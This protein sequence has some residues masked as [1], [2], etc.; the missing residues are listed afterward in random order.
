MNRMMHI[1]A[2][3]LC[4]AFAATT[5]ASTI[6]DFYFRYDFSSGKNVFIGSGSL[7]SDPLSNNNTLTPVYGP[8]GDFNAVHLTG[9]KWGA[10][11]SSI[12]NADWSVAMCVRMGSVEN[13]VVASFG[14][15]SDKK[16]KALGLLSSSDTTKIKVRVVK[17]TDSNNKRSDEKEL[18]I[19]VPDTTGFH[20]VV[21]VHHSNSSDKGT[22][23]FYWDGVFKCSYTTTTAYPL[24]NVIQF[25]AIPS[26][27]TSNC[28]NSDNNP[29]VAFNDVRFF[30]RALDG[31]DA[32]DFA[33]LHPA[34]TL[35]QPAYIEAAGVNYIDTGYYTKPNTRYT[36]DFNYLDLT[37]QDRIFGTGGD[38]GCNVYI[39]SDT[40]YGYAMRD[41]GAGW[42]TWGTRVDYRRNVATLDATN[43]LATLRL[44]QDARVVE[45]TL[46][47]TRNNTASKTTWLFNQNGSTSEYSESRIYSFA[48]DEISVVNEQQVATPTMFLVPYY[49]ETSGACFTNIVSGGL[50][51]EGNGTSATT[52]LSYFGG[53]G[54]LSDYKYEGGILSARIY[55]KTADSSKGL[56]QVG[57]EAAAASPEIWLAHDESV[58]LTAVPQNGAKFIGWAGDVGLIQ[59]DAT[60]TNLT[61]T[62]KSSS[63]AQ[64]EA[65]FGEGEWDERYDSTLGERFAKRA[66]DFDVGDYVQDGL[67][68]NF[69]GIRNAGATADHDSSASTWA[70]LGTLGSAANATKTAL[71]S[72]IPSG[73]VAG[74]W[75]DDGYQ[76]GGLEYFAL[77]GTVDLGSKFT[78]QIVQE[79]DDADQL[80]SWPIFF[81]ATSAD[82]D[83]FGIYCNRANSGTETNPLFKLKTKT[84][85]DSG[86]ALVS[87]YLN[88]IYDG[89]TPQVS[90]NSAVLPQWQKSNASG[91][92]PAWSYAIGTAGNTDS[93]RKPRTLV[94]KVSSVRAYNRILTDAEL[95]L[96][97]LVDDA[98]F[99]GKIDV[100][101]VVASNGSGLS[102]AEEGE[103]MVNGNHIFTAPASVARSDGTVWEPAGYKLE[104]WNDNGSWTLLGEYDGASYAYTNCAALAKVRLTWNWKMTSG[105]KKIDV[106]DYVQGGLLLNFDGIRNVGATAN[107]D[108]SATTW[109]NLGSLGSAV[110]ATNAVLSSTYWHANSSAGSWTDKGYFFKCRDFF[111][112]K[113]EVELSDAATSQ[114]VMDFDSAAATT[115]YTSS[116]IRWPCFYGTIDTA[117]HFIAYVNIEGDK[118]DNVY[119][120][121]HGDS[122]YRNQA[123]KWDGRYI[124]RVFDS[125]TSQSD[126][127]YVSI[128]SSWSTGT[129]AVPFGSEI[130]SHLLAI[131]TGSS[132]S[133]S[134][135][136]SHIGYG[137]VHAVR[138]YDRVLSESEMQH[139]KEIDEARFFGRIAAISET[140]VVLAR[141]ESAGGAVTLDDD[142]AYILR[143]SGSK[144]FSAPETVEV[145]GRTYTCSGYCLET[146]NAT[147]GLWETTSSSSD[148]EVTLS[149]TTD[150]ANRRLTWL[151]TLTKGLRTADD[152]TTADYVQCGLA[153][154]FDG[155]SNYG[156]SQSH[157]TSAARWVN[158]ADGG[159]DAD[160]TTLGS[161]VP[162]GAAAG[163][164]GNNGYLFK[165]KNYFLL[166]GTVQF[167]NELT[168][169]IVQEYSKSEQVVNYPVYFG[170][171]SSSS[172]DQM[173]VYFNRKDT[174]GEEP[175]FKLHGKTTHGMGSSL[176]GNY[177]NAF[178]DNATRKQVSI[179]SA[180]LPQWQTSNA[181][182]ALPAWKYAIGTGR[183]TDAQMAYRMY[184]GRISSVRAYNRILTDAELE[185]NRK[186]DEIRYGGNFTNYVNLVVTNVPPENVEGTFAGAVAPGGYELTGAMTFT[187]DEVVVDGVKYSPHYLVETKSGDTWSTTVSGF[188]NVVLTGG[189]DPQRLTWTWKEKYLI[190]IVR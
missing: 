153:E 158:L 179:N 41:G 86:S 59:G 187:A 150:A 43:N 6:D 48:V 126:K 98:R 24:G 64:F 84:T 5:Q 142:G 38:L 79:Y 30:D 181:S 183:A 132:A 110:D 127:L 164:W 93:Y 76:F 94:G 13:G 4:V 178:Y 149:C 105:I 186:V 9:T 91:A 71:S 37:K 134:D 125:R 51:S 113:D 29:D 165:G 173:F 118:G 16:M 2:A 148:R 135:W 169:Q 154:N 190:I 176:T 167:G 54:S 14:R 56:V 97:R 61:I 185:H 15:L 137:T 130:G 80:V 184:Y 26:G 89:D 175:F 20:T 109:A 131:G 25:M 1:I 145:D 188:G 140:D 77:G 72:S 151:W 21:I 53:V 90:I 177:L 99:F 85:H 172:T 45:K 44:V 106:D 75:G 50:L 166:D 146:Q 107:H 69:D 162:S 87:S 28:T 58:T 23:D 163:S 139:N 70:N 12:M 83:D 111:A 46:G 104:Q 141:C 147:S 143:G 55:A 10:V 22:F 161:S 49:D 17:T 60:A 133:E 7:V 81:G 103:Y 34:S 42:S 52:A 138:Q 11:G 152:Y 180:V 100:N 101:V 168:L 92:L 95:Q 102:G 120:Y 19:D 124:N 121:V 39:N 112:L 27:Y 68:L 36:A 88:A 144:T 182:D 47:G 155:L 108:S 32:Q 33:E 8:D 129:K 136:Y 73:A 156:G 160:L 57:E 159:L 74:S 157:Y 65:R 171:V 170:A 3:A 96:N 189:D 122:T 116:G 31:S 117:N 128:G 66:S 78:V 115:F 63:A 67:L 35:R 82:Q 119:T 114:V 174:S 62:V 18:T 123:N 40:K